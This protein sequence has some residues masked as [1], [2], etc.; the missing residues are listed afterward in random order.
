MNGNSSYQKPEPINGFPKF[1][2]AV[3]ED[4]DRTGTIYRRF[5]RLSSRNLLLMES[6]IAE[7]EYLQDKYDEEDR[8]RYTPATAKSYSDWATFEKLAKEKNPAGEPLNPQ[9]HER[10]AALIIDQAKIGE[11]PFVGAH[12]NPFLSPYTH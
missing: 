2:Y 5:D 3:T 9:V 7:L 8:V 6:E 1:A 12:I 4:P 10:I 11:V